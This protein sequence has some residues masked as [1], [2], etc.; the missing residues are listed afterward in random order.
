MAI[1]MKSISMKMMGNTT[2]SEAQ[3]HQ[4]EDKDIAII[5][6][7]C[8]FASANNKEEFWNMLERGEDCIRTFP[9]A[10]QAR[11]NEFLK[12]QIRYSKD[13]GYHVG[14]YLDEVNEFDNGIFSISPIEA[15]LMSP[16]QR[17][18]LEVAWEAIEDS[19]YGGNKIRNSKTGV[20]LGHSSDF[21]VPYKEFIDALNPE[22]SSYAISG[23]LNSIIAS[24]I[25]G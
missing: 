9:K 24:T 7:A 4:A 22:M 19:G 8:K 17:K 3:L 1:D 15:S 18:F 25:S 21:G 6:V 16:E 10:R 11:G 12:H 20:F 14:G 13:G 2:K 5:G 23:N